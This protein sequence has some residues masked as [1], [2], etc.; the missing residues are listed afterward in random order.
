MN[1]ETMWALL[2]FVKPLR[3]SYKGGHKE[4]SGSKMLAMT[5][6]YLGLQTSIRH[7]A[8]QF[9]VT[10]SC[11]T[12]CTANAE[13]NVCDKMATEGGLCPNICSVQQ[14]KSQVGFVRKIKFSYLSSNSITY[15]L[16]KTFLLLSIEIS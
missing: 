10:I 9:G 2:R 14:K 11:F 12:Y 8:R 4:I 5:L 15:I 7:L 13:R 1:T 16:P 6:N 3:C